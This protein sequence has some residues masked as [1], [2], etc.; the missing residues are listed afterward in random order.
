L[1]ASDGAGCTVGRAGAQGGERWASSES[2]R[3]Q[4]RR[5]SEEAGEP[6]TTSS[7]QVSSS[8]AVEIRNLLAILFQY[9][10]EKQARTC[11]ALVGVHE[12]NTKK[13]ISIEPIC[14]N[15]GSTKKTSKFLGKG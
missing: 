11:R 14:Q 6:G 13:K 5:S 12:Y 10:L 2:R 1:G 3:K 15:I 8:G 7:L 4:S 9:I